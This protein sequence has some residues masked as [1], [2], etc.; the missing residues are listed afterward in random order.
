MA[1]L[2]AIKNAEVANLVGTV[3]LFPTTVHIIK[4]NNGG[5]KKETKFCLDTDYVKNTGNSTS[6]D[7]YILNNASLKNLSVWIQK[8]VADYF[9]DVYRPINDVKLNITQSWVNKTLKGEFHHK[10][11]HANS[12]V[13]GVYYFKGNDD[14]KIFFEQDGYRQI[15]IPTNDPVISNSSTWWLPAEEGT[16]IL[17]PSSLA[18]WVNPVEGN[19]RYSLSFNTFPTGILGDNKALTELKL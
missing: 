13:S 15:S 6:V 3:N 11:V 16:L 10:H 9:L 1:V 17:F 14:D 19:A 7:N 18:H 12:F 4:N 5:F 2:H 8:A